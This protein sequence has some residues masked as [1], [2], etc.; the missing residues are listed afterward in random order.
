MWW[1]PHWCLLLSFWLTSG[2]LREYTEPKSLFNSMEMQLMFQVPRWS[3]IRLCFMFHFIF[4]ACSEGC[5][6]RLEISTSPHLWEPENVSGGWCSSSWWPLGTE[7][8]M[9]WEEL[10]S[11]VWSLIGSPQ[12][13]FPTVHCVGA[14]F[15]CYC[16]N[17][18]YVLGTTL[19]IHTHLI[20][21]GTCLGQSSSHFRDK[22]VS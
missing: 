3:L 6:V 7:T 9:S 21:T 19:G 17:S 8:S 13:I 5:C 12:W 18:C 20:L 4:L 1:F 14:D 10:D 15:W 22:Y 11:P 16:F 2:D